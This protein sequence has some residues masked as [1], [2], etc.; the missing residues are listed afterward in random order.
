MEVEGLGVS[1][2]R[3]LVIKSYSSLG[4][5]WVWFMLGMETSYRSISSQLPFLCPVPLS[6]EQ[7][8]FKYVRDMMELVL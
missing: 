6:F 4:L 5:F 8:F 7:R 3:V 1:F 2:P